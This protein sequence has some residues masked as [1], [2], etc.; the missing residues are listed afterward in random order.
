MGVAGEELSVLS[1][2]GDALSDLFVGAQQSIELICVVARD[3]DLV[4]I[5]TSGRTFG[6]CLKG[7]LHGDGSALRNGT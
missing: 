1:H 7:V 5:G 3:L 2:Q 4:N 6:K